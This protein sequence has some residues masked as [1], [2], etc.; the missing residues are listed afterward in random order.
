ML[1]LSNVRKTF[2]RIV[3]VDG[4]SLSVRKGEVLGLLGPNGAGK[5]TSVSLAV[6]LL[7]PESGTVTIRGPWQ[8]C[9]TG[10][11]T[12]DRRRAAG[13]RPL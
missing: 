11:A 3:A 4:L 2:G 6:G 9:L 12:K 7:A 5:S 10:G 1:T 8:S 13:P